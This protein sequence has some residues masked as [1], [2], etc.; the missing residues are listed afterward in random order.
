MTTL[1]RPGRLSD[2]Q[3]QFRGW[4]IAIA[5]LGLF[6]AIARA[7]QDEKSKPADVPKPLFLFDGKSLDGWKQA[8]YVHSG[9]VKVDGGAI[10][11]NTGNAMTG[12]TCTRKDHRRPTMS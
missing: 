2:S 9:E 3:I 5:S 10:I 6:V 4:A 12:I 8:D 11:L 7:G 1:Q